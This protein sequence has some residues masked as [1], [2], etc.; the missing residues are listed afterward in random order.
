MRQWTYVGVSILAACA[1]SGCRTPKKVVQKTMFELMQ[2]RASAITD[3]GGLA[4]VGIGSSRTAGL[5]LEKAKTRGRAEM[6]RIMEA[7]VSTL[8]KDFREEIGEDENAEYNALF[9]EATKTL[10]STV[11]RGSVP[12]DLKYEPQGSMFQA[13]ALMVMDPKVIAQAFE[14]QKNSQKALYTRFRASQAFKELEA[15]V[16][17]YESFKKEQSGFGME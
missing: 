5:S 10:A 15:D 14:N 11:L 13:C 16:E 7:K 17:K 2:E 1:L 8:Q 4:A 6:A 12:K 3:A 9:S